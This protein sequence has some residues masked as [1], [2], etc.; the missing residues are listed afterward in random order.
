MS[1]TGLL[2]LAAVGV[3]GDAGISGPKP[4][5]ELRNWNFDNFSHVACLFFSPEFCLLECDNVDRGISYSYT[6]F[7]FSHPRFDMWCRIWTIL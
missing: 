7:D 2:T 1:N 5:W 4:V 3:L 6:R